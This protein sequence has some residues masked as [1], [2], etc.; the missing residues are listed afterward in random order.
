[1]SVLAGRLGDF[2]IE[3]YD[4]IEGGRAEP[5]FEYWVQ[6]AGDGTIFEYGTDDVTALQEGAARSGL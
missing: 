1:M 2:H 5:R 6:G 4:V 3:L